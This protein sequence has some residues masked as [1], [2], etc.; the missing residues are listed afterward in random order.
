M[1]QN[2]VRGLC[3]K[4]GGVILVAGAIGVLAGVQHFLSGQAVA[5]LAISLPSYPKPHGMPKPLDRFSIRQTRSE[6]GYTYWVLQGFGKFRGFTLFDTWQEAIDEVQ[7]RVRTPSLPELS[8]SAA[9]G[10]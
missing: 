7:R 6:L 2:V 10:A 3:R 5:P 1:L 9:V 4:T 8:L